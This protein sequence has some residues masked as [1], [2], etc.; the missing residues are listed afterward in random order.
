MTSYIYIVHAYDNQCNSYNRLFT[1][2]TC[3]SAL[4]LCEVDENVSITEIIL[5]ICDANYEC[6]LHLIIIWML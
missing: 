4:H 1:E 2:M 5:V 6:Q 3:Q